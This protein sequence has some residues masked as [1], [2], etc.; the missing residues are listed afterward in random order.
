MNRREQLIAQLRSALC[1]VESP[2][3][4]YDT[5]LFTIAETEFEFDPDSL[6]LEVD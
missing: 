1:Q 3:I 6:T 4:G 2:A 5:V